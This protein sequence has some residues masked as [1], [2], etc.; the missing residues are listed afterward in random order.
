MGMY[1]IGVIKALYEKNL[2]P[3]IICGA[4]A[5]SIIASV[6]AILGFE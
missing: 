5:G 3:K 1:H 4:S 6:T 2:L